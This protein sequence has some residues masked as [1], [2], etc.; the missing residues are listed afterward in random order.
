MT[1]EAGLVDAGRAVRDSQEQ[2]RRVR[3]YLN[4][5]RHPLTMSVTALYPPSWRVAG[6]PLLAR[7][8]WLPPAPIPLREVALSWLPGERERSGVPVDGTGR[9]SAAV[10]PLRADGTRFRCYA[11]ALDA[12]SRPGLLQNRFCY[13]LLAASSAG[14]G[15][16]TP[17]APRDFGSGAQLR[18]GEGRY[19]DV[20]NLCEAVAHEYAAVARAGGGIADLPLR[21]TIGDPADLGRRPVMVAVCTLVLRRDPQAGDARMILHWRDPSRVASGGG[22][23]QVAPAGMFQPSGEAPWNRGN[24]FS[25]FRCIAREMSEELLGGTEDYHSETAP[26]DYDGWPLYADLASAR[27]AGTL[28]AYWLGLG[29]DPLT[30][31]TDLLTVA[32]F[33]APVFDRLLGGLVQANDEGQILGGRGRDLGGGVH[34]GPALG[35]PFTA[36]SVARFTTAEPMQPAGAALL[37]LAWQHRD[38]LLA[39]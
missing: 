36:A 33:D 5:H 9:A 12:I 39:G 10:R 31:A 27:R 24:D 14:P 3:A 1:G 13:R 29:A 6:T 26:I 4:Q 28:R 37:R 34:G 17:G 23:Y 2:W 20:I 19:F 25:L 35:I 32:V 7:D 15:G 38:T 18:F 21:S 11:D 16:G 22:M 30:L 8:G